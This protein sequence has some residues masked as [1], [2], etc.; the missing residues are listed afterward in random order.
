MKE[1][2]GSAHN[3]IIFLCLAA[4]LLGALATPVATLVLELL[5]PEWFLFAFVVVA[6]ISS[7]KDTWIP[8]LAPALSVFSPRPPPIQ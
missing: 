1:V 6:V 7:R 4:A 2:V 8:Q 3:L 5:V